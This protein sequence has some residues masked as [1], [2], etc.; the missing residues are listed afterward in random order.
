MNVNSATCISAFSN[1]YMLFLSC[2]QSLLKTIEIHLY[3]HVY[4][5]AHYYLLSSLQYVRASCFM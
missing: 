3:I 2:L 1:V 5:S 4:H